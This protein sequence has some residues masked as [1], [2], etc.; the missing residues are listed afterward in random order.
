MNLSVAGSGKIEKS[1]DVGK[2]LVF[3]PPIVAIVASVL[4]AFFVVW[5]RFND[6][7]TL[8]KTNVTLAQNAES[9]EGKVTSLAAIDKDKLRIQLSAAEQLVPSEKDI[10]VF[11]KQVEEKRD[12]SGVKISNLSVGSVGQFSSGKAASGDAAAP[13]PPPTAVDDAA[14]A[15]GAEQVQ[16]KLSVSSDYRSILQFLNDLYSLPRVIVIKD[17]SFSQAEGQVNTSLTVNGLWQALPTELASIEA[18]IAT[19]TKDDTELLA[20]VES[21]G[22]VTTPTIVPQV[23]T[24]KSDPFSPFA[25]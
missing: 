15:A 24:N 11:I 12:S 3:A 7:L 1:L 5:P 9:L 6:V 21:S 4:V 20:K 13:P 18:P 19:L 25:K 22:A 23:P 10:F 2:F 17:V 16:M 14:T 8:Q